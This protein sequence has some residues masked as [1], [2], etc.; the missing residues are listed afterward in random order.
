MQADLAEHLIFRARLVEHM[1]DRSHG[2]ALL[3]RASGRAELQTLVGLPANPGRQRVRTVPEGISTAPVDRAGGAP[4]VQDLVDR[5]RSLPP[6]R[7]GRPLILSVGRLN[8]V[9]GFPA[10]VDAWAG[11]P[12]LREAFNLV[13]VGGDHERP[14]AAGA[15]RPGR[16][17]ARRGPAPRRRRAGCCSSDTART[18]TCSP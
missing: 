18:A 7:H 5:V 13:I 16:A 11:D 6:A 8:P 9:K 3:P 4:A 12:E 14:D 2:L 1:R 10:L 17:V 15:T